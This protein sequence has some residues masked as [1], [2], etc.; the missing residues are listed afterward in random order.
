MAWPTY[1]DVM[2]RTGLDVKTEGSDE[3]K[4]VYG[5]VSQHG[6]LDVAEILTRAKAFCA[7]YCHRLPASGFDEAT[8]TSEKHDGG[9]I[10]QVAHPPIVTMT[11][12]IWDET[13][14]SESD[15]DYYV[16]DRYVAIPAAEL[17]V[18]E[19][20]KRYKRTRKIVALTY[21]GGYSDAEGTHTAIPEELKAI[22]LDVACR[23]VLKYDEQYRRDYGASQVKIGEW[24]ATFDEGGGE[25]GGAGSD[26]PAWLSLIYDRL[27]AGNWFV[28]GVA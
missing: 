24:W 17:S 12:L 11:S 19:S 26:V 5:D 8:I 2:A 3:G 20:Y 23:W 10:L 9:C 21:V 14:L 1:T 15:D 16:Y 25:R 7:S 28:A 27:Q 13:T 6:T 18:L 4:I 22:V